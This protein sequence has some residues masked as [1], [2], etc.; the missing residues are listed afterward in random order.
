MS[1]LTLWVVTPTGT[2]P[3]VACDSVHLWVQEDEKGKQG[4]AYG[5]RSGHVESLLALQKGTASAYLDNQL[6]FSATCGN[7][8]ATVKNDKVTLV[9]EFCEPI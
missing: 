8:F 2:L 1:G 4:G 6:I 3:S 7:G 5:I 9:V